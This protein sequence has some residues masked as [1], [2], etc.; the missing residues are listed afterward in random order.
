MSKGEEGRIMMEMKAR[1]DARD[2]AV[3]EAVRERDEKWLDF[4]EYGTI[5][6]DKYRKTTM[7][8]FKEFLEGDGK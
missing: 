6:S 5:K 8:N 7:K 1:Q 2:K 4:I 3:D